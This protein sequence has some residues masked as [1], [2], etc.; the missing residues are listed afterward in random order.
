MRKDLGMRKGKMIAQGAHASLGALLE[1]FDKQ[2]IYH[3]DSSDPDFC[4]QCN[5]AEDSILDWWL[6]GRFTKICVYVNSEEE[7]IDIYNKVLEKDWPCKLVT[8]SGLTEFNNVPTKT[9]LC[10][11]PWISEELDEITGDLPLL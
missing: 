4:Y 10:V 11:G 3:R 1:L 8:D 6:N 5:F 7:L 9:C 2:M